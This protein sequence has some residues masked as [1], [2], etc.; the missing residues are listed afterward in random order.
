[1]NLFPPL[2]N[3]VCTEIELAIVVYLKMARKK[4]LMKISMLIPINFFE[5]ERYVCL[6][7][8]IKLEI[9]FW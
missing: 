3:L 7:V 1:M 9:D 2:C 8:E 6:I 5:G 4:V